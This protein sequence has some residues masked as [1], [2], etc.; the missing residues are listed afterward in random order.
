M[1]SPLKIVINVD[2]GI[3]L[4]W[5]FQKTFKTKFGSL[6]N[7][8]F[9]ILEKFWQGKIYP[10]PWRIGLDIQ[11]NPWNLVDNTDDTVHWISSEERQIQHLNEMLKPSPSVKLKLRSNHFPYHLWTSSWNLCSLQQY[12]ISFL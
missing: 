7:R 11:W 1:T 6:I 2:I 9:W 10:P 3:L 4:T 5:N 8:N 12:E